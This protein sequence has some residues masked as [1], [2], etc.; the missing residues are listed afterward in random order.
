[1]ILKK[2]KIL[3]SLLYSSYQIYKKNLLNLKIK[4]NV[5]ESK[6]ELLFKNIDFNYIFLN[7]K[8]V[9]D[10]KNE[11][12]YSIGKELFT[13][14]FYNEDNQ[15]GGFFNNRNNL[16]NSYKKNNYK[17]NFKNVNKL[18]NIDDYKFGKIENKFQI[19]R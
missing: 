9:K 3:Y 2:L 8:E 19:D 5:L 13:N 14:I 1:M 7:N 17:I 10:N 11:I 6:S 18:E 16:N 4:S 15:N 12:K